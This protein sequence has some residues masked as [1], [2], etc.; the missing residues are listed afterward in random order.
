MQGAL[1][2]GE[3]VQ[4][5]ECELPARHSAPASNGSQPRKAN[6]RYIDFSVTPVS[7]PQGPRLLLVGRDVTA[8]R[9]MDHMKAN[10]LSMVSHELRSPLQTISGYLDLALSGLGGELVPKQAEFVRRAR[11]GSEHMTALVDDLLLVSRRDAGEFTL[12]RHDTDLALIA[13]DV[14][15][16]VE[17]LAEVA[18]VR[19]VVD[20]PEQP[21]TLRADGPRMGQ[22]VRNLMTNAIKFTPVGGTVT[23]SVETRDEEA[24]LCVRDTGVG[25]APEHVEKIFDR[26]YQVSAPGP[27]ARA[28]GQGLGLAIVRII[29]E[30]HGGVI[31]VDTAP[32]QGSAF[33]VHLPRPMASATAVSA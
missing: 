15:Q 28:H 26:F 7:S 1:E 23:L 8:A 6:F 11:A 12:N 27:N 19:L 20:L 25:I 17:L 10:F 5:I 31:T 18:G 22:V 2:T 3:A 24:L 14:A 21:V 29:V 30:G 9:E 33:T 32:R 13:S 16:E 4:H